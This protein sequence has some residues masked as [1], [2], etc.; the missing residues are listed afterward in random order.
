MKT[1]AILWFLPLT[2]VA[3]LGAMLAASLPLW[4]VFNLDLDY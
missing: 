1:A 4:Q 2:F 3:L